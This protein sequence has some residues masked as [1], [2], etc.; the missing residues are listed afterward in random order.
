MRKNRINQIC[1][2]A[3][4]VLISI[5]LHVYAATNIYFEAESFIK[6]SATESTQPIIKIVQNYKKLQTKWLGDKNRKINQDSLKTNKIFANNAV[7]N[8]DDESS[9]LLNG[10]VKFLRLRYQTPSPD[11]VQNVSGL[12][13]LPP[14]NKPKGIVLFFHSTISGKLNVPSLRFD[15]Y[16]AQMLASVFAGNGYIVVAPD[17]IGLGDNLRVTHPYILYPE[18]NVV[19][20]KNMLL[21]TVKYL[22]ESQPNIIVPKSLFISGYSEGGSYA[23]WF[24]RIYQ[25]NPNFARQIKLANLSLKKTVAIEGAYSLTKVMFPFLLNNQVRAVSNPFNINTSMWGTL[26]K[27]SLVANVMLSYSY[28]SHKDIKS[29]LNEEFFGLHCTWLPQSSCGQDKLNQYNLETFRLTPTKNLAMM[30]KY[31][32]AANFKSA[33]GIS[34]SIFFNGVEPLLAI[35]AGKSPELLVAASKADIIDW[36]STNPVTLISLEH[37]SLVPELNSRYAY[38]GMIKAG[39]KNVKY[40]KVD[41]GLLKSKAFFGDNVVDHVSFELYALLIALNEFNNTAQ[42]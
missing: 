12:I 17:Y 37:D 36:K 13:L 42:N 11:G 32:F 35:G 2:A 40:L 6:N 1:S 27:P 33:N 20:G 15:D 3:L 4:L 5:N 31:F 24:S 34:Y 21:S 14:T 19:D 18:M 28:Y 39:S 26:L 38:E 25:E 22:H 8:I 23:L 41:N 7:T 30:L 29:L 9:T 16:K 10:N